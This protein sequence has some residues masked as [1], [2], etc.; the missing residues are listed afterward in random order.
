VPGAVRVQ[1]DGRILVLG[2][3]G[4]GPFMYPSPGQFALLRLLPDGSRDRTFGTNGFVAWNPPWRADAVNSYATEFGS[5]CTRPPPHGFPSGAAAV[6][7]DGGLLVSGTTYV[8]RGREHGL[9]VRYD[10]R[11]CVAGRTLRIRAVSAGPPLLQARRTA[12]IGATYD[13]GLALIRIRR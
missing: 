4:Y 8:I 1:P 6:T 7:S 2:A 10:K 12:L 3:A 9:F 5:A 13:N 11:G